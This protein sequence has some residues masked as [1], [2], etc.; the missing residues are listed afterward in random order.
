MHNNNEGQIHNTM[1]LFPLIFTPAFG[2]G[3]AFNA[4]LQKWSGL[5]SA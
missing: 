3:T 2:V 1:V 4:T 5:V